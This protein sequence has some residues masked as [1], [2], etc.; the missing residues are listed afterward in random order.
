MALP[1]K[2]DIVNFI[3]YFGQ[4]VSKREIARGFGIKG[5]DRRALK[6]VLKELLESGVIIKL[7]SKEYAVPS[8]LPTI[9]SIEITHLDI[10]GNM[11]AAPV[12]WDEELQ[13][14]K[15]RIEIKPDK[16]KLP[17]L[18]EKDRILA[19]LRRITETFYEA[20]FIRRLDTPK[21]RVLGIITKKKNT[22]HLKPA[23]KKAKHHFEI[24]QKDL[25]N[26][27]EGDV[28]LAEITPSRGERYKKVRIIDIIGHSDDPKAISLI[29]LHESSLRSVFPNHALEETKNMRVPELGKREDLRDIP[30]VTIDGADA[31][32]FDDA[33]FAEPDDDPRNKGGYH[34]IVAIAD[35]AYYVR[36]DT[37]LNE[38]AYNRGNSTY[39]P[40]RV[41]PMLPEKLSN[42]LCSLRPKEPRACMAVHM[43]ID[44]KGK[45]L[46]HKFVRGLMRSAARL[47]YE[48][49]QAAKDGLT[50]DTTE[51]L[52]DPVI[53]PLYDAYTILDEARRKRGALELDLPERQILINEE[54][55][56]TGVTQRVR[57]DSH[58]LIEEFMVLANVA[59][60][61]AL[62]KRK[63]PCVYR[64]HERPSADRL[65]NARG[66]VE[67]FGLSL[68]KGQVTQPHQINLLL[69]KA[70]A[71]PHSHLISE[72]I[73]RTQAQARYAPEN[74]GHFGLA[75]SHYAHFTS[76]IRRYAD[77]L[78]HRSLIR[79]YDLGEGGLTDH[80][81]LELEDMSHHISMTERASAEAERN[82]IDRFTAAYLSTQIE[83][84]FT[85]K[86]NGVTRFGLFV[87][88]DESG[89]DGLIPIRTL[90]HDF[91]VH[92]EQQH[93]L[94]GRQHR[95]IYRLGAQVTIRLKEADPL[96]GST[97]FALVGDDSADIPG[98][99]IKRAR[100]TNKNPT[101]KP[102]KSK[103][104]VRKIK[105]QKQKRT[106]PKSKT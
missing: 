8:A 89:A 105:K 106:K 16:K 85:G 18:K 20:R 83:A 33:V 17:P 3:R 97:I 51:I 65:D 23:N 71:L 25:N 91:Y 44:D 60:A 36:H 68:P 69:E 63:A 56:M 39:F 82:A 54:G 103:K 10:D 62:E 79:A 73:L 49:V 66:F 70:A 5:D 87:T 64:V 1:E 47:T 24:A 58:K 11:F 72:V 81:A 35:V 50:D 53:T 78:V 88:L 40:D 80:E 95:R 67:S 96:T 15:P 27:Q 9:T 12:E 77:L 104:F 100:R 74:V 101:G 6:S 29:A 55:R 93:A 41:L 26:A 19:R 28:A 94:I 90:P 86:I 30:L 92:D 57:L 42:D 34:L 61:E 13:G 102:H 21:D 46:R 59:A 38:E 4:P 99:K 14:K 84:E 31:R 75:L 32:D 52:L 98:F 2:E 45:L 76:P 48:Q 22:F 7:S 43:W 37:S